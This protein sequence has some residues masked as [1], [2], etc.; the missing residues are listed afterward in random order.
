ILGGLFAANGI[1]NLQP[2]EA[3]IQMIPLNFY[4][5][6]SIV[7][8]FIVAYFHFD[9]G[10]M[11]THEKRAKEKGELLDPKRNQVSGDLGD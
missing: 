3:F 11:R 7:L 1:T 4:A 6:A 2:I 10:P 5:I 8:V 9:I